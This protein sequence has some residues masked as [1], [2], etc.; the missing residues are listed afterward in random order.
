MLSLQGDGALRRL[1]ILKRSRN[2]F[3]L[4]RAGEHVEIDYIKDFYVEMFQDIRKQK[5]RIGGHFAVA[6]VL[7]FKELKD[8]MRYVNKVIL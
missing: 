2:F 8:L 1:E 7:I 3:D 6:H 4:L 5:E